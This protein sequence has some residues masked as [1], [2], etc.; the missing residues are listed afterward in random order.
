M[1]VAIFGLVAVALLAIASTKS[2]AQNPKCMP[3]KR[4]ADIVKEMNMDVIWM[5]QSQDH[6]EARVYQN[7]MGS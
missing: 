6:T 4:H 3:E 1:R 2:R 7:A 5:G